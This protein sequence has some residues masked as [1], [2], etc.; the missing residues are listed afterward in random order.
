MIEKIDKRSLPEFAVIGDVAQK[1]QLAHA[2]FTKLRGS[3]ISKA[4]FGTLI[5]SGC[6]DRFEMILLFHSED[7]PLEAVGVDKSP[8]F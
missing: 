3:L 5:P 7:E 6:K 4:S 2:F 1:E 8:T